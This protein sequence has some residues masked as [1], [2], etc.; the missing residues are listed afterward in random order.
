MGIYQI[1][2]KM[3]GKILVGTALNLKGMINSNQFA[4]KTGRHFN[5]EL[6]EDFTKYGIKAFDF[7]VLDILKPSGE[8]DRNYTEE[9][10]VLEEMWMEKIKPYGE[11]GYHT[12]AK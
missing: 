9:L 11:K 3:T 6:Q 12:Q 10:S 4:L 8:P 1:T 2:N 7:K 5:K